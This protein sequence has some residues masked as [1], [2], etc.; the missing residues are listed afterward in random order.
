MD[1]AIDI[2]RKALAYYIL[3]KYG[4][5]YVQRVIEFGVLLTF[6]GNTHGTLKAAQL[7]IT[8]ALIERD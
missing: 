2:Y 5:A 1:E 4:I 8:G 7:Y 3:N 6:N